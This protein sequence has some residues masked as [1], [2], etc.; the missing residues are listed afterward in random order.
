MKLLYTGDIL[1]GTG[2]SVAA[3]NT[4]LS[5]DTTDIDVVVRNMR[6]AP[7]Y[8]DPGER[9]K[10]LFNK[11]IDN[12]DVVVQNILAPYFS[13]ISGIKNIGYF[14]WETDN[15]K[16]SGWD[17]YADLMDE[18]WVSCDI[19]L[20]TIKQALPDK[21]IKKVPIGLDKSL[22]NKEKYTSLLKDYR[23]K[24]YHIGDY[25]SRKNIYNL[26][27]TYLSTFSAYDDV[28]LIL[29][30][31][32][33][34]CSFEQSNNIIQNDILNIKKS[35]RKG[36][37]ESYPSIILVTDYLT[38]HQILQLHATGD[39]FVSFERGAAW[40][41]PAFYAKAMGNTL[42]L[43]GWGGQTEF[44]SN[45]D[46]CYFSRYEMIPCD[47]MDRCP[48]TNLYT[49]Y[50]S[51]AEPNY[52]DMAEYMR[53]VYE[54][55]PKMPKERQSEFLNNWSYDSIGPKIKDVLLS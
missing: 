28:V 17:L 7:Q 48:Y 4:I 51:W 53:L 31:Y 47:G 1:S 44:T 32:V 3:K 5:I 45:G 49:A 38:E 35:L 40:N 20:E 29:K 12:V 39:C 15:I 9:I 26:I 10:S 8:N 43:N 14:F 13:Y 34:G 24:F 25:S 46:Y 16:P 21:S 19:N 27:K 30:T 36:N 37:L 18:I 55:R 11:D 54:F 50:E 52:K 42:I 23:Y 41:L 6:L 2:Y 33:E 22:F